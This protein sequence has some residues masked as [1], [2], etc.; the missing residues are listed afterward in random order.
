MTKEVT[1]VIIFDG[2]KIKD[3]GFITKTTPHGAP[4]SI[5][6][7]T[8]AI[9]AG[10]SS[11]WSATNLSRQKRSVCSMNFCNRSEVKYENR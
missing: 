4:T 1:G 10:D 9:A 7:I 3:A 2:E 8:L 5:N 11:I 6:P